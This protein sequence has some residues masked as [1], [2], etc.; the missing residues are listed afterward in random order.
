M[1]EKDNSSQLNRKV[2]KVS[3]MGLMR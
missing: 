3:C 1:K 2:N